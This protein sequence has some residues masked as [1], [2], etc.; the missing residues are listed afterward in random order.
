MRTISRFSIITIFIILSLSLLR[1]EVIEEIY[2]VVNDEII[3]HTE[4]QNA[5]N[6]MIQQLSSKYQ[7]EQLQRA[8]KDIDKNIMDQLI[9][10]KLIMSRAKEKKY[11]IDNEINMI[12]EEIKKQNNLKSD[13]ELRAALRSEGITME[14]FKRQQG[15]I[16][17]QQRMIYDEVTSKIKIEN[18]EIMEY[19]K[20]H[21][22][23]FTKPMEMTLNCIFLNKE[24][25]FD[26]NAL[27]AKRKEISDQLS[28]N[29]F[30]ET[31][32]EYSELEG[33]ENNYTLGHFKKGELNESIEKE[34]LKLQTNEYS[35]WIETD[36]GWYIVQLVEK[37]EEKSIE[38]KEVREKIHNIIMQGKQEIELKKLIEQLR[39]ESYNKIYKKNDG[40]S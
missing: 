19:Y 17:M 36:N 5:K 14:E 31:A 39:K 25:Y 22:S 7:G 29:N 11:D 18:A 24:L 33:T 9:N 26:Q 3:T 27:E 4:F 37:T 16:R 20:Q 15:M 2:A 34:A 21:L 12:L 1:A 40:L 28:H 38:Y 10:F 8:M 35:P 30:L 6:A 13:E 23:E 32:K